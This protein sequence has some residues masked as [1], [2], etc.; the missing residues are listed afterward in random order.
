MVV[1]LVIYLIGCILSFGRVFA[2]FC[3]V[4]KSI[5]EEYPPGPFTIAEVF[6][7]IVFTLLS[8]IGFSAGLAVW[9][10]EEAD[11]PFFLK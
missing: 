3:N 8:W 2:V 4:D 5:I 11:R 7:M 9:F 10:S 6:S 1:L